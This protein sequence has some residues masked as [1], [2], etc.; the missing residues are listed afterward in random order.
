MINSP[1][2]EI[3]NLVNDLINLSFHS[4]KKEKLFDEIKL[5]EFFNI[6]NES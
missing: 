2:A 6:L 1:L 3:T 5:L 4:D